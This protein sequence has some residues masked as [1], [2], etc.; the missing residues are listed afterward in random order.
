MAVPIALQLYTLRDDL[1]KDF[2]GTIR[3]VAQIGFVGV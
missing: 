3:R 2:E 1:A